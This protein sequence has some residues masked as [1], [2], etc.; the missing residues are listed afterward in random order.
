VSKGWIERGAPVFVDQLCCHKK[1]K[2]LLE[3]LRGVVTNPKQAALA[4]ITAAF[5]ATPF[6]KTSGWLRDDEEARTRCATK[7]FQRLLEGDVSSVPI[8]GTSVPSRDDFFERNG[9][10]TAT[11]PLSPAG[12]FEPVSILLAHA[13]SLATRGI[14][15][16]DFHPGGFEKRKACGTATRKGS[17]TSSSPD[18]VWSGLSGDSSTVISEEIAE[19][20]GRSADDGWPSAG[21]DQDR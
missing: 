3:R 1:S 5:A 21:Q 20:G 14:R 19:S 6:A 13:S 15:V 10:Y 7:V 9:P 18:G 17:R 16:D 2:K 11:P 4:A 8:I 12:L